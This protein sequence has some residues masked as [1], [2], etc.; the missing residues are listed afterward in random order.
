MQKVFFGGGVRFVCVL[1][2]GFLGVFFVVVL[3][4]YFFLLYTAF[5]SSFNE[6]Q[7]PR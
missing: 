2:F 1:G 6:I 5:F 7:T 3:F 4:I